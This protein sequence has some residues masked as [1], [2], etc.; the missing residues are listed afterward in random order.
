VHPKALPLP[1]QP[2]VFWPA[3]EAPAAIRHAEERDDGTVS[4]YQ[5]ISESDVSAIQRLRL[6]VLDRTARQ[7]I[8]AHDPNGAGRDDAVSML[9]PLLRLPPE[10]RIP[11]APLPYLGADDAARWGELLTGQLPAWVERFDAM[12]ET[13]VTF[14][15]RTGSGEQ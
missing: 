10:P 15:W 4:W 2:G 12:P 3:V 5:Y 11:D 6:E 13:L 1:F 9:G 8:P 14:T 7:E